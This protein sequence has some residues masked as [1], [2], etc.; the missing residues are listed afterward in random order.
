[1]RKHGIFA[2]FQLSCLFWARAYSLGQPQERDIRELYARKE[3]S[4]LV[5]TYNSV[6]NEPR[7]KRSYAIVIGLGDYKKLPHL[8]SSYNDAQRVK[9]YLIDS[10]GFD[11]VITL[12]NK[13]AT[14]DSI[15][16]YMEE[17]I[18]NMI[19]KGDRFLFY[20]SGHGTQRDLGSRIRGYLPMLGSG[21][22]TWSDMISMEDIERWNDNVQKAQHA[23]FVLD[24][25]FSGLAGTEMK[26][27]NKQRH[28]DYLAKYGHHLITAGT[29][30]QKSV[31]S[32]KNWEGS[33]FTD[34]FIKG[35]CGEA[36]ATFENYPRDGV[37]SLTEVIEYIKR[38]IVEESTK[39]DSIDQS[40]QISDLNRNEGEFFFI[41]D[42]KRLKQSRQD[43]MIEKTPIERKGTENPSEIPSGPQNIADQTYDVILIL[44]EVMNGADILVDNEPAIILE[45]AFNLVKIRVKKKNANHV[46]TV[47]K[48]NKICQPLTIFINEKTLRL[49]PC[50]EIMEVEK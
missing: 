19:N 37:V 23:L 15:S 1:M 49:Q 21:E 5:K 41:Y 35:I 43:S 3:E 16:K 9:K 8:E 10:A 30:N 20:F 32:L 18:P 28:L 29:A 17:V 34:A 2:L 14:R 50:E 40:P 48:G 7:F 44:P 47:K 24:C 22:K 4:F 12:I 27:S 39:N 33:L 13:K 6:F 46:I 36:D 25:C 38:R 26:G 42:E 31:G 45:K 11:Y